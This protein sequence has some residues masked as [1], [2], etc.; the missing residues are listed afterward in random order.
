[1]A[2]ISAAPQERVSPMS[3]KK[4]P[5]PG[6]LRAHVEDE[7]RKARDYIDLNVLLKNIPQ[8]RRADYMV[9]KEPA[10]I[11]EQ[12]EHLNSPEL[13]SKGKALDDFVTSMCMKYHTDE[14]GLFPLSSSVM[15][16]EERQTF[17]NLRDKFYNKIHQYT[18]DANDQIGQ[19]KSIRNMPAAIGCMLL[20]F[21]RVSGMYPEIIGQRIARN[22]DLHEGDSP[23]FVIAHPHS[24]KASLTR[25]RRGRFTM[26]RG[27]SS[28]CHP[29]LR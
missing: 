28:P 6:S 4:P 10:V 22:F 15:S 26:V 20:I 24:F 9:Y 16:V 1:M 5:V 11:I 8:G 13:N 23:K 2:G 25:S 12:K 27:P 14:S 7:M 19:T 21:D 3:R 18:W 29:F 17:T